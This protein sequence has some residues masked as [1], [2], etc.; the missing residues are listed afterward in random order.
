MNEF[1]Y[2][3]SAYLAH[4]GV[5]GM[6][7]G[8]RK[9]R[10]A[11][12]T[13]GNLKRFIRKNGKKIAI[14]AGIATVSAAA[15]GAGLGIAGSR[16]SNANRQR[17]QDRNA[18]NSYNKTNSIIERI[19]SNP[20]AYDAGN[21]YAKKPSP[22]TYDFGRVNAITGA[23]AKNNPRSNH[24]ATARAQAI[25]NNRVINR[26]NSNPNAHVTGGQYA[27][28]TRNNSII[29]RINSNPNAYVTDDRYAKKYRR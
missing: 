25:Q 20:N 12:R 9:D 24:K 3:D 11:Y 10:S 13:S 23:I 17:R 15:L 4:H 19:N 28:A 6:K 21:K 22:G 29:D 7:W 8:V 16:N 27:Q 14:G 26:I 18:R 5:K 1:N 2:D